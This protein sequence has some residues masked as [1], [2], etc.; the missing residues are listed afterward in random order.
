MDCPGC[1]LLRT[2]CPHICTNGGAGK[3]ALRAAAARTA[4][5]RLR[6][7]YAELER[8]SR[9]HLRAFF[10]WQQQL[11]GAYEP[12]HLPVED[13]QAIAMSPKEACWQ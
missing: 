5:A 4:S 6:E 3:A 8:G 11:G 7:L 2:I 9:N 10:R 12:R 1:G 13:F